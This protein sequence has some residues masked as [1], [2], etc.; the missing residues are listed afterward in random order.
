[1]LAPTPYFSDRGCHV[2]IYEEAH[3]LCALGHDVRIITY[4][5]GRDMPGIP[6][7]RIP[8]IPWYSK[9]EA[10]PSLHKLYLDLLL[11][12]KAAQT[13]PD[14]RPDVIHAHLHEGA[15]IGLLLRKLCGV[16]L[17]FDYQGS[18]TGECVDHGFF[19][20]SS[21]SARL[22]RR[23]ELKINRSA[24]RIITSSG[25][26]ASSLIE[27]WGIEPRT[28][29]PLI[30]GVDTD[31]FCAGSQAEARAALGIASDVPVVAYLGL[32][33]RYQGTDLLLESIEI[34]QSKGI[35]ALFLIMGFPDQHYR[36]AT[37]ARR[38]SD[39]IRFTGK[40]NYA[41]APLML[42]AADL[43]VAPKLSP[44]EANGKIFNYMAC[45]LPV[46]AFDTAVNREILGDAGVYAD[47]GDA[48]DFA[49]KIMQLLGDHALRSN[50]S[51]Q[52]RSKALLEHSWRS[53][54]EKLAGIYR[55][56]IC[57]H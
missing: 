24:D 38:L 9:H 3:A 46:V 30:D 27:E 13:I 34:V 48:A 44:T 21:L 20:A 16:P 29:T 28:V 47:F 17:L 33:N 35:K 25:A 51:A 40:V 4:H 43:A 49:A 55:S 45:G 8:R 12:F 31:I 14:F 11:F 19:D 23:I 15:F 32:M 2:R 7:I 41:D 22:F 5:L 52:V 53:R 36:E 10:G 39:M 50:L 54:A 26:G 37:E 18:L 57:R 6:V 56:M 1:M 42:S